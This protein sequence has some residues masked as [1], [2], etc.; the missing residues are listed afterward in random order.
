[1]VMNVSFK[2]TMAGTC[3]MAADGRQE[4]MIF[5]VRVTAPSPSAFLTGATM[6]LDG[7]M[8]VGGLFRAAPAE[9]ELEV[10][11]LGAGELNYALRCRAPDG[12]TFRYVGKKDTSLLHPIAGMTVLRGRLYREHEPVGS[13]ELTFSLRDLPSFLRSFTLAPGLAGRSSTG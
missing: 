10:R 13:A 8:S 4:P 3:T 9:G 1:M 12:T 6:R 2:E 7:E 11:I 5:T